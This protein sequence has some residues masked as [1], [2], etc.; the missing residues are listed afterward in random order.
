MPVYFGNCFMDDGGTPADDTDDTPR[1]WDTTGEPATTMVFPFYASGSYDIVD[2]HMVS[3]R[4]YYGDPGSLTFPDCEPSITPTADNP[5]D[6]CLAEWEEVSGAS[7]LQH[8]RRVHLEIPETV[9][10]QPNHFL[11]VDSGGN[12]VGNAVE[13][14]TPGNENYDGLG[15]ADADYDGDDSNDWVLYVASVEQRNYKTL[16]AAVGSSLPGRRPRPRPKRSTAAGSRSRRFPP[17]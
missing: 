3:E 1:C 13:S 5:D 17:N 10:S 15:G 6:G 9:N 16:C 11:A 2:G 12:R 14:D 7:I 8:K 4:W